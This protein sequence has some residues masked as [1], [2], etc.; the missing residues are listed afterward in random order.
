M[1]VNDDFHLLLDQPADQ[2]RPLGARKR[3]NK[4][5]FDFNNNSTEPLNLPGL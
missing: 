5:R 1:Q 4:F 3:F 2:L